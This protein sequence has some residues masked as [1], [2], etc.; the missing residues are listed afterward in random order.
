[1]ALRAAFWRAGGGCAVICAAVCVSGRLPEKYMEDRERAAGGK[2]AL[3]RFPA[4]LYIARLKQLHKL[5]PCDRL[6][7]QQTGCQTVEVFFIP[8]QD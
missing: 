8:A 5:V 2:A 1:M 3:L 7:L 4:C 6:L